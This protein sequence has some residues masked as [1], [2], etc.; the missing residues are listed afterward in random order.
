MTL[1][2]QTWAK[3]NNQAVENFVY[4]LM[5]FNENIFKSL[6]FYAGIIEVFFHYRKLLYEITQVKIGRLIYIHFT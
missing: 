3:M 6:R 4:R 5:F 2:C 1:V